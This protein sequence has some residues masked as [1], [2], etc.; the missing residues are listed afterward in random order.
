MFRIRIGFGFNRVRRSWSKSRKS[1]CPPIIK[2]R[3]SKFVNRFFFSLQFWVFIN[4][5]LGPDLVSAKSTEPDW[6]SHLQEYRITL[7]SSSLSENKSQHQAQE[8]SQILLM[9]KA[10]I[11]TKQSLRYFRYFLKQL[12]A[13]LSF[14]SEFAF[15]LP[16]SAYRSLLY[17][18]VEPQK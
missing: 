5:G 6:D 4:P 13:S 15:L 3:N 12:M 18:R 8:T 2:L 10:A 9:Y 16:E 7:F 14:G 1:K 11:E 17:E